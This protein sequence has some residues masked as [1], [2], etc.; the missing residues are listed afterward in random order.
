ML[1]LDDLTAVFHTSLS[2]IYQRG[3]KTRFE[4]DYSTLSEINV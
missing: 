4:N 3:F 2:K 1:G